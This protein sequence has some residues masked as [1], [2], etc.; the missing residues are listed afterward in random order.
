M[1]G[2]G[3]RRVGADFEGN[4]CRRGL[5]SL[6]IFGGALG[7]R[8]EIGWNLGWLYLAERLL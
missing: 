6:S 7:K 3:E 8:C 2:W 5:K 4:L 1:A